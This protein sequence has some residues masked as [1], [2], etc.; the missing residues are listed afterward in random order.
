MVRLMSGRWRGCGTRPLLVRH[1]A[2]YYNGAGELLQAAEAQ[3]RWIRGGGTRAAI[4]SSS[5][6]GVRTSGHAAVKSGFF[7]LDHELFARRVV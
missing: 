1:G 7:P 4:R 3:W 2:E 6:R 5:S